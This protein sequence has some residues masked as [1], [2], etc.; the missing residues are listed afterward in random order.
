MLSKERIEALCEDGMYAG[1]N[2]DQEEWAK[3]KELALRALQPEAGTIGPLNLP[4]P[5]VGFVYV[6]QLCGSQYGDKC[7]W[8]NGC[9]TGMAGLSPSAAR[10]EDKETK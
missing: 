5:P 6:C 10:S 2:G 8:P 7:G 9:P 4:E 3:L 1:V